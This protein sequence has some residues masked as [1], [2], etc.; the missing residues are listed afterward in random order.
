MVKKKLQHEITAGTMR[1]MNA[2]K[3]LLELGVSEEELIECVKIQGADL[4]TVDYG[5]L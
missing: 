4:R 1:F 5:V 3:H 2:A